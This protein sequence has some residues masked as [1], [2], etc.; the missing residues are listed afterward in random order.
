MTQTTDN[1]LNVLMVGTGEYTTGFV[2]GAQSTSDKKVGVIG[3]SMFDLRRRGKVG[4]ISIVGTNG[5]KLPAIREHLKKNIGEVYKMDTT[6]D[7][8]CP[9]DDQ[10]DPDAYKN[11]IDQYLSPGD[12]ITVFTPDPT[13]YPIAL[14]A[15]Q[16]GIHVLLTKPAVKILSEH[17]ELIAE[18]DKHGVVV[19]VEHHKRFDPA[20]RD[21]RAKA[22]SFGEFNY[23]YSYMSQP[24]R[25]LD[26]F[27]AWAGK[28]SDISYYLNSHHIDFHCWALE[29]KAVPYRV[30]A[31]GSKGVATSEPFN[32]V[33]NTEDTISLLVNWRSTTNPSHEG[34]AVYTSSWVAPNKSEV[35]SQQRFHYLGASGELNVDQAHRGYTT[36]SDANGHAFVNPFYMNY[37]PD[38]EGHFAGQ[39]GYGYISIE[40]FVDACQ[41]VNDKRL[42]PNDLDQRQMPTIRNTV[43][44]TAILEAGRVSLDENRSVEISS[45]N[46]GY[47]LV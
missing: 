16:R 18:A 6:L 1:K 20:Y 9:A 27:R 11:A 5:K 36:T 25:Q 30:V 42:T 33:E 3:L 22:L 15:I 47:T 19:M 45:S 38:E 37:A 34:V 14:Y 24:K 28:E 10:V 13:H 31:S 32:L 29:G 12:A 8:S 43:L 41:A 21:A 26:T 35:H 2:N 17:Q 40:K 23:F 7:Y 4:K 46:G 39:T 44:V